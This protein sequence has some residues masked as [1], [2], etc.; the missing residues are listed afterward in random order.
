MAYIKTTIKSY[1]S[2]LLLG[3]MQGGL[4]GM[5]LIKKRNIMKFTI[6]KIYKYTVDV[7]VEADS[8]DEAQEIAMK[9]MVVFPSKERLNYMLMEYG[10][11][12]DYE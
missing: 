5:Y 10:L 12:V 7:E 11:F 1:I 2:G 4:L 6:R 8:A 3:W 9:D